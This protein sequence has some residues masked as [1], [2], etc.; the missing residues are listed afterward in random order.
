MKST[1]YFVQVADADNINEVNKKLSQLLAKSD[2]LAFVKKGQKPVIKLHFGEEGTTGYVRPDHL[3]C[4]CDEI[5]KKGAAPFLSDANTLYRGKRLNSK[6]HLGVALSHGFTKQA[7]GVDVF[8]PDDTKKDE[9]TSVQ[10]DQKYIK[11]AKVGRCYIEA[12]SFLAVTHFKGHGMTGFGGTLK[13]IG[14]GC[15]TREG[16]LAQHNDAAPMVY[17]DKCIGCGEC[18][19]VC[20]ADAIRLENDKSVLDKKKCIGC[21]SCVAACAQF[22]LFVDF[23]AGDD[24]QRKMVEYAFAVLKD[25]KGRAGFLN[26]AVRIN[27]EC[28]CWA[29]ENSRI[30]PDVGIL[31]S[32]DPVAIDKASL[33]MVNAA[34]GKEIFKEVHPQ[35]NALLQLEYAQMLGLGNMDYELIRV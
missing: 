28:D 17:T 16:K 6:D 20:P 10:I 23:E 11:T 29:Y 2:V 5:A 30:A 8:I 14:M 26:F 35:Q 4:I 3:R 33:D 34:C 22:A 12:D 24:V 18:V 25:K 19:T 1:V 27:K 31:A 9:T 15:A 13:N 21:A 7:T 32:A